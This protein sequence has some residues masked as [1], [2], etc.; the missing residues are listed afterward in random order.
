MEKHP[1]IFY[2]ELVSE[3]RENYNTKYAEEIELNEKFKQFV[4]NYKAAYE[5]KNTR[6]AQVTDV[7][8]K[9]SVSDKKRKPNYSVWC[10]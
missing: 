1:E 9:W 5:G 2:R 7:R 3:A 4:T 6:R 8:N 10:T